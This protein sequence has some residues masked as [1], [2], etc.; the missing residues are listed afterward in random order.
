MLALNKVLRRLKDK[1]KHLDQQFNEKLQMLQHHISFFENTQNGTL[2]HQISKS[3][4]RLR[5]A[6][7]KFHNKYQ[8]LETSFENLN[9]DIKGYKKK[10]THHVLN[11]AENFE[12]EL[13]R[14][15]ADDRLVLE[16]RFNEFEKSM[17][18]QITKIF[19]RLENFSDEIFQNKAAS[20][21]SIKLIWTGIILS[22]F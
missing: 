22:I 13:K 2:D 17:N 15:N 12:S 5:S 19:D 16:K 11:L 3:V 4:K 14:L 21:L 18:G 20:G 9:D 10:I 8:I 6:I 1:E 7:L